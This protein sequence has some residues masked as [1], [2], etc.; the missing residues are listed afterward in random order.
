MHSRFLNPRA[1][2]MACLLLL[3][4]AA[5]LTASLNSQKRAAERWIR[6]T[7]EVENQLGRA[8][9]LML[10]AEVQH[11]GYVLGD[12]DDARD[13]AL[14]LQ[15]EVRPILTRLDRIVADNPAQQKRIR[16]LIALFSARVTHTR[17]IL[18]HT[19]RGERSLAVTRMLEPSNQE[20]LKRW[21]EIIGALE[22][23]ERR[24]M[25]L[26]QR[27]SKSL[28]RPLEIG[29][30]CC[31][32]L[33]L[34]LGALIVVDRRRKM[35]QLGELNNLLEVDIA[36]RTE[37]EAELIAARA[38]AEAAASAK[39]SFL[40]NMSHEIRT[41]MNGVLGFADLLLHADL[42]PEQQR[43][44]QMIVDSGRAMMR[45]LNDIL[46]LSKIEAG[47]MQVAAETV[48]LRHALRNCIK[49]VRPAAE[50]KGLELC[51]EVAP[52]L[53]AFVQIDG[54]RLRQIVLN[55][56]GNAVKFTGSGGVTVRARYA[57]VEADTLEI[58]IS[59]TGMGIAPERLP[60]IFEE[61]VQAEQ[62]TAKR[63]GGTGLGLP[64]SK[65]LAELMGGSLSAESTHGRGTTF[66]LRL[67]LI[68]ADE[69]LPEAQG[70]SAELPEARPLHILL[71]EDHDVNQ[72]LMQAM[73]AQLGHRMTIAADGS[74]AVTAVL[75]AHNEGVPF[76]LVL[77]D[78]QMPVLDGVQAARELRA[79]GQGL[80]IIALTANAYADDVAAC[81]AAGMQAHLAKPVQV[82]ELA[83]TIVRWTPVQPIAVK[84]PR[85][86]TI[87]P[88]LQERYAARKAE[89]LAFATQIGAT[90]TF[91]DT[92]MEE[93]RSLLH[94]LAGSAGM[95]GEAQLGSEAAE[96]EDA[97]EAA[98]SE[99]RPDLVEKVCALKLAA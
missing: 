95:F 81:L 80:P 28:E 50:Q 17:T 99:Q 12:S 68:E 38:S 6:H 86:L 42:P 73:L 98:T 29:I 52:E 91:A 37:L 19:R 10:R 94:K 27:S 65:R 78:M 57:G 85:A 56:V 53:P 25:E 47:Q 3:L 55:L 14:A 4:I 31:G 5:G 97:L 64:I 72:A 75:Q 36:R 9:I 34:A 48:E 21:T 15:M 11:R 74:Q 69:A 7:L 79:A 40:A 1:L 18:D 63:F 60:A 92:D 96:L 26:R 39:S 89:L 88:S 23:E 76:D 54:L 13:A 90:R 58:A 41:P 67:P 61:F 66:L 46:D 59:D 20:L 33:V 77:M 2:V 62:S 44:A 51:F 24:L 84:V 22:A 35:L 87:D 83:R 32:V 16:K 71:A 8:R 43:Q 93:L 30:L 45:L 70:T 82:A 49:L